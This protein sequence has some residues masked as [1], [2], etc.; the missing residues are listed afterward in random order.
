MDRRGQALSQKPLF[1]VFMLAM[2]GFVSLGV[3]NFVGN[4][5]DDTTYW[6]NYYAKDLGLM[7]DILLTERGEVELYYDFSNAE[8]L[9]IFRLEDGFVKLH[10][11]NPNIND[12]KANPTTFRFAS[13][14]STTS[15]SPGLNARLATDI[16]KIVKKKNTLKFVNESVKKKVCSELD[17]SANPKS[18]NIHLKSDDEKISKL[19][20]EGLEIKGFKVGSGFEKDLILIINNGTDEVVLFNYFG[21]IELAEKMS[22][23]LQN[24]FIGKFPDT[25]T[26]YKLQNVPSDFELDEESILTMVIYFPFYNENFNKQIAIEIANGVIDY[27]G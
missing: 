23:I 10:D 18:I 22:C 11:Y 19:I 3:F 14:F 26:A 21:D 1:I 4:A 12:D 24:R 5:L 13:D 2:A 27:Y 7:L 17:T 15:V 16:F 25:F 8:K 9:L 20:E 6:R